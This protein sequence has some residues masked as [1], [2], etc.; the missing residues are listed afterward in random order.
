MTSVVFLGTPQFAVP[1]LEGL[2]AHGYQILGVVTQPDKKVGRKQKLQASPVKQAALKLELPLYQ[3]AKLSRSEELAELIA[4]Q[5]DFLITAA[6]GQFLPAKL[7]K[8]A[9]IAPVNV[10]GSLLPKY[11]GGAPIQYALLNGDQETGITIMEMVKEMDAGKMY[12][13]QTVKIEPADTAG[14]LFAKLSIVGRDLLL[15]TLPKIASGELTGVPQD[16][17]KV[18]FSPTIKKSAAQIKTNLSAEQAVNLIRALNPDP[19]AFMLIGGNRLKVWQAKA[20]E[21]TT[22][23]AAG[24]LVSNKKRFAIAMADQTVLELAEVQAPGKKRMSAKD[25]ANGQ[26]SHYEIGQTILAD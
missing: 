16:P 5:P 12:A 15:D 17:A 20:S 8:A 26:G 11:R 7:L 4:L 6:Y 18:V 10:H 2:H 24:T 1:I 22:K 23:Q 19:G 14:S 9:K 25:F 3:P 13:Q 21:E